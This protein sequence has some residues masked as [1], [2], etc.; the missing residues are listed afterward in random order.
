M[1]SSLA[2]CLLLI[3]QNSVHSSHFQMVL[4]VEVMIPEM[5]RRMYM[6]STKKVHPH[7][8]HGLLSRLFGD[9]QILKGFEFVVDE[10]EVSVL[11]FMYGIS[12][13]IH[14]VRHCTLFY[15]KGSSKCHR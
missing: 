4:D 8:R 15:M 11:S 7:A 13:C 3:A 9:I 14:T 6:I 5:I 2:D 1:Y 12:C 10:E